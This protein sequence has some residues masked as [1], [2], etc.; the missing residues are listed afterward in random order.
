[1]VVISLCSVLAIFGFQCPKGWKFSR[2]RRALAN[3]TA[4]GASFGDDGHVD[5]AAS[6]A[7]ML[8]QEEISGVQLAGKQAEF[9]ELTRLISEGPQTIGEIRF[10][11]ERGFEPVVRPD[12][13]VYVPCPENRHL[14]MD[15]EIPVM[16]EDLDTVLVSAEQ[17]D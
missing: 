14:Y 7:R 2:K 13:H 15:G 16:E 9:M 11:L 17:R 3:A 6:Y 1:M 8:A 10:L 12:G 5:A 4:A